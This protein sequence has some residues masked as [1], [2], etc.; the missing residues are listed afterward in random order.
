MRKIFKSKPNSTLRR[1]NLIKVVKRVSIEMRPCTKY[2][3]AGETCVASRESDSCARYLENTRRSCNLVIF[4]KDWDKLDT[5]R[6]RLSKVLA[7]SR[8]DFL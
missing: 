5:E 2:I 4:Q 7:K 3:K 1:R 8:K 6:I